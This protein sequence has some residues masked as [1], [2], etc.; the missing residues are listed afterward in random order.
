MYTLLVARIDRSIRLLERW[1]GR[2]GVRAWVCSVVDLFGAGASLQ[3]GA[4]TCNHMHDAAIAI[5]QT[6]TPAA[7]DAP[8]AIIS[9]DPFCVLHEGVHA[10]MLAMRCRLPCLPIASVPFCHCNTLDY[11]LVCTFPL[12][13][14]IS[15]LHI[16]AR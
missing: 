15:N 8:I 14:A 11:S 13:V 3:L 2:A 10:C 12:P 16:L 1:I 7:T 5:Q 9:S 4:S 6:G